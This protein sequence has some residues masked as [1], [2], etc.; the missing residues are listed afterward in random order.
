MK[1]KLAL[2][3]A[4]LLIA[5]DKP[6]EVVKKELDK[7][8]GTWTPISLMFDGKEQPLDGKAGF[9]MVL[10]GDVA[11]TGGNDEIKQE[12]AKA[13]FKLNPAAKP[14]E[15]DILIGDGTQKDTKMPAIYEV[16]D[17]RLRLC[18]RLFA[19]ERPTEFASNEGSNIVLV[20]FKREKK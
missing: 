3:F 18:I 5:A 16:F 6:P 14:R 15:I 17:D 7:L 20:E 2:L 13:T 10:K 12:Y 19:N 1:A 4:A 9:H 8:Q 11:T